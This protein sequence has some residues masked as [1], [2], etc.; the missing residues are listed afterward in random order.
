MT[1]RLRKQIT[2]GLSRLRHFK[3]AANIPKFFLDRLR[4]RANAFPEYILPMA[5][6]P[7]QVV[8]SICSSGTTSS[9]ECGP[10]SK[11][12]LIPIQM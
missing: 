8:T 7:T 3:S 10:R 11:A 6:V 2:P 4:F 1:W 5:F 9:S 12:I